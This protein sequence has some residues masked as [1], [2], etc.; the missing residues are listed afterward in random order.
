MKKTVKAIYAGSFDP[1]TYGHLDIIERASELF[2]EL[3]I[4]VGDNPRKEYLFSRKERV[5]LLRASLRNYR[6]EMNNV[7]IES[8]NGLL[9]DFAIEKR[10]KI[11]IRGLRALTDFE[12]EF[13]MAIANMDLAPNIETVFLLTKPRS[14]PISSSFVKEIAEHRDDVSTY[15]TPEVSKALRKKY[16]AKKR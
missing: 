9:V 15:T 6:K 3:I 2:D 7:Q 16:T 10:A 1:V 4:A 14:M 11:I 8:F 12:Q 5:D 13:Q